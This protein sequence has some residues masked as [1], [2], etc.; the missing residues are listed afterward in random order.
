MAKEIRSVML[1]PD[2]IARIQTI[3]D[4]EGRTW[5]DV[6]RRLIDEA[7]AARQKEQQ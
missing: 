5:S 6:A 7:L 4:Y 2:V 3:A 1:E